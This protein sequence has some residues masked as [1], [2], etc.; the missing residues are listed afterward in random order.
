MYDDYLYTNIT[1]T[2]QQ[3]TS[4]CEVVCVMVS[5]DLGTPVYS[6]IKL[7]TLISY[8][9]KWCCA[10]IQCI[11]KMTTN[12][13]SR[14]TFSSKGKMRSILL[15]PIIKDFMAT[16]ILCICK[17][18]NFVTIL[19]FNIHVYCIV[20]CYKDACNFICFVCFKKKYKWKW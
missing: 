7:T 1:K 2:P 9:R 18:I 15:R 8:C 10:P 16:E 19:Y 4:F 5:L 17:I 20:L 11:F 13:Q 6:L 12:N 14:R 3:D